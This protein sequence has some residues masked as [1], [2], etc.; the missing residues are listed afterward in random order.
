MRPLWK[1]NLDSERHR[2]LGVRMV[3]FTEPAVPYSE[4][5]GPRKPGKEVNGL[6]VLLSGV[7]LTFIVVP[8]LGLTGT[9]QGWAIT[10]VGSLIM[11]VII[12]IMFWL[13]SQE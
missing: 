8:F 3:Q 13:K 11:F 10:F 4:K 5:M 12:R 9:P 7:F 1:E 2:L 6:L